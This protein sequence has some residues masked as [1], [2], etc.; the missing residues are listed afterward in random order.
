M[1]EENWR[2][3]TGGCYAVGLRKDCL[4]VKGCVLLDAVLSCA[5]GGGR[6]EKEGECEPEIGRAGGMRPR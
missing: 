5:G 4:R 1:T 3:Q 2:S 6:V